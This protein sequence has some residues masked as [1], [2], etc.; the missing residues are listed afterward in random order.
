[1]IGSV[2]LV[3]RTPPIPYPP[4][5]YPWQQ[6]SFPYLGTASL[7]QLQTVVATCS[8]TSTTITT[9]ERKENYNEYKNV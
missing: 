4:H 8:T 3:E 5:L 2:Y 9:Q 7:E 6:H 1:M